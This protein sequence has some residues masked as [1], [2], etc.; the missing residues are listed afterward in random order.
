MLMK[1]YWLTNTVV[2]NYRYSII[3]G[4]YG[5][6]GLGTTECTWYATIYIT[7]LINYKIF[8]VQKKRIVRALRVSRK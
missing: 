4:T 5:I 1:A 2:Y 7:P 3:I 6:C 8:G